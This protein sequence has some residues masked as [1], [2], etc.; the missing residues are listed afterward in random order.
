MHQLVITIIAIALTAALALASVNYIPWWTGHAADV[1]KVVRGSIP[2]LES[3]YIVATRAADGAAPPVT[4][5]ADGGLSSNF[6]N[7]LHFTPAAP[8]HYQWTY[9]IH[10]SDGSRYAN[11]NYFCM[12]LAP[13]AP[14]VVSQYMGLTRAKGLFSS[15]QF[16]IG[17]TCGVTSNYEQ[18]TDV[19]SMVTYYVSYAPGISP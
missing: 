11:L 2:L 16:F 13:G 4:A 19:P 8:A 3:A 18:V 5:E 7:L 6:M 15:E 1:E 10:S 14:S 9:G 17:P 12:R